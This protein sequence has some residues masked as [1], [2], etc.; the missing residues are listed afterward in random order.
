MLISF[1]RDWQV[2]FRTPHWRTVAAEERSEAAIG[3]VRQCDEA[4][5]KP[6]NPE[7]QAH[8]V[9]RFYELLRPLS[10][11]ANGAFEFP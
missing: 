3:L 1:R 4:I 6:D 2:V 8:R 5:V 7:I 10:L 9:Y 11:D